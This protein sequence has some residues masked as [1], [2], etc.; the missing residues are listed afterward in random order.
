MGSLK[1][2]TKGVKNRTPSVLS[3]PYRP[4][5]SNNSSGFT[6]LHVKDE[7][8]YWSLVETWPECTE[9]IDMCTAALWSNYSLFFPLSL[10]SWRC[11]RYVSQC[12]C[13][14]SN[15]SSRA[16]ISVTKTNRNALHY[17]L[18]GGNLCWGQ[19]ATTHFTRERLYLFFMVR[20]T[21]FLP[22]H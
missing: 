8:T 19:H 18:D 11:I 14:R 6:F 20:L 7:Y 12:S 16:I 21:G 13:G 1:V 2:L 5:V 22:F 17:Y 9:W 10:P 3:V 4:Y 15:N